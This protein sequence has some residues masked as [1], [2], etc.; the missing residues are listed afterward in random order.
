HARGDRGPGAG[1]ADRHDGLAVAEL[2]LPGADEAVRDMPA[3]GDV[4]VVA[5]VGLAHVEEL[6]RA[7]GEQALELVDRDG[8]E[9]VRRVG[10][11]QV[12]G[13]LDEADRAQA[14]RRARDLLA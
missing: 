11:L 3:A 12:A 8:R 6:D 7:R 1:L 2:V 10:I 14:A 9:P 5:L 13:E 4:A